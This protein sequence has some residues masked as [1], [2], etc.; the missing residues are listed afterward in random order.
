MTIYRNRFFVLATAMTL[1]CLATTLQAEVKLASIFSDSMV[2]QRD[3]PA[4]VWGWADPGEQ[5]TVTLGGQTQKTK[6]DADGRWQVSLLDLKASAEGQTLVVE[7]TNTIKLD[8]VLIGE[9]WICSGQSNMEWPLS[10]ATNGAEE[11]A[12]ADHPQ[13]RLF[14]VPGHTTSPVGKDSCPGQWKV[15][16][17]GS[18]GGFSAV[19]YFF[20]RRL[21]NELNVPVGLVGTNWGGTRI[22]PWVSPEGFH[23]VPELKSIADQVDAYT[24]ETKVG[25]SSPSA[26]YNAMVHPLVPFSM[27]GAIWYQGESNGGEGESYYHKT[28]ALV[29]S[30]RELFNPNLGFYWVQL[31]NFKQ[32]TEDPAGG[33]GWAKL[34]EAQTKALDIDH[35]GMAVITDIGEANDIHP[36]NKQDVGDRLAQWA[37]HQTYDK[38]QI[39]PAGP[40]FKS[41]KI[42]GDSIR[43]SFNHVGGGLIVGQ[44]NGLDPTQEVKEGKLE[45]FAIAGADKKW[46]W[47]DATIDG[48]TVVVKSPDV[49]NPVAVRYA[50]T[51]NP[52]GANLYNKEGIPASPFRTDTW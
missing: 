20:G 25:A 42:E 10:R 46:H 4:P 28:R 3:L 17:P 9:V 37:L 23:K 34:R 6:A 31:A 30:W 45:R 21:Q 38:Q 14:N 44:K 26:I 7:G 51:M 50:Y 1:A 2:L 11:V 43:L 29:S 49:A 40:L 39:V 22:E 35:T 18:A 13:I 36:K 24:A 15:C 48:D 47:A 41:Q 32:P 27:R 19:G 12:A 16:H 33:D 5:V 8:D 52:V